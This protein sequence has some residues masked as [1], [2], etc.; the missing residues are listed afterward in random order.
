MTHLGFLQAAL[1]TLEVLRLL[2]FPA[3]QKEVTSERP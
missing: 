3:F 1:F 2:T